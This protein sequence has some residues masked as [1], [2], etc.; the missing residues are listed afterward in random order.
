MVFDITQLKKIRRQLGLT[1]HAF[2]ARAGISQ[3]MVAKIEAG[4]LDPTYS[5]VQ[6]I[7]CALQALAHYEEKKAKDIMA[8]RVV[9][10]KPDELVPAIV[11]L[12]QQRGIS[13]VPVVERKHVLGI[14][15][16]GSILREEGDIAHLTARE[17]MNEAPPVLSMEAGLSVVKQLLQFYPCVLVKE[18]EELRGIITKADLLKALVHA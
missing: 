10:V 14:I 6:Q 18:K 4:R 2:A 5:K 12:M 15:S 1:Q 16:E 8:C 11:K 13:Q 17:V 9:T 3:S 7:E